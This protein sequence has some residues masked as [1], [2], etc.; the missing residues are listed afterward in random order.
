MK[1]TY[2]L[3]WHPLVDQDKHWVLHLITF[4]NMRGTFAAIVGGKE[5][6]PKVINNLEVPGN[7][8]G[9]W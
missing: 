6:V 3:F 5:E 1:R 4:K 8:Y 2:D 9:D 7:H